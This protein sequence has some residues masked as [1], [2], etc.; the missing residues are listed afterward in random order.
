VAK[1]PE[2]GRSHRFDGQNSVRPQIAS[3]AGISVS[4]AS[5]ITATESAIAGPSTRN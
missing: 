4:P 1:P 5:S 3:N 2:R